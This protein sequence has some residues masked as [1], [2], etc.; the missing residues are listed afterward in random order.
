MPGCVTPLLAQQLVPRLNAGTALYTWPKGVPPA[1]PGLAD[2]PNVPNPP[3]PLPGVAGCPKPDGWP[4][5]A[6][7]EAP[8]APTPDALGAEGCPNAV[9][10]PNLRVGVPLV[11]AVRHEEVVHAHLVQC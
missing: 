10:C 9:G 4:K 5:P 7:L 11:R 2:C 1:A 3:P 6:A 8:N